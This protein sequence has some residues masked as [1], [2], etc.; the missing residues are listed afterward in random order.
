MNRA[1]RI[2]VVQ[3]SETQAF[4]LRLLLEQQGWQV[5]VACAAEAALAGVGDPL[6]DL[7][8]VDYN[9]PGMLGDEFCRRV[10]MNPKTR[11][12]PILM[13]TEAAADSA[14]IQSLETGADD[15]VSKSESPEILLF[16]IRALLRKAWAQPAILNP[17]DSHFR[18][19]RILAIDDGPTYLAFIST[20]L[21]DLGYEVVTATSGTE[22]LARLVN[23][24]FDCVLVDLVMPDMD[25][26]EVCRRIAAMGQTPE[27]AVAVIILTASA[28]KGDLNRGLEA[29]ADDFVS[30]S[31]DLAVLRA[32]IQAI[33]RR[34]FFQEENRPHYRRTQD[35]TNRD[36][37]CAGRARGGRDSRRGCRTADSSQSRSRGLEP[38]AK[39]NPGPIDPERKDGFAGATGGRNRARDQQSPGLCRE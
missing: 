14:E 22:G 3:D 5:S 35:Q 27:N 10:R 38:E 23:D 4:K 12:I 29:G 20:E 37:A 11:S 16:R 9:L 21:R 24:R 26:I 36:V 15:Y 1:F 30:K 39:R 18:P 6:P 25:G 13:L 19:A 17:Q 2:V 8:L 7:I 33:M 32:R 31:S 28:N 34:R